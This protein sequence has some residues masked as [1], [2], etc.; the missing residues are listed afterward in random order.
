MHKNAD[1]TPEIDRDLCRWVMWLAENTTQI[2]KDLVY[3][4]ENY[5][6]AWLTAS[7]IRMGKTPGEEQI[8]QLERVNACLKRLSYDKLL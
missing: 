7:D 4:N 3:A 2:E 1:K 5:I 6:K 8:G